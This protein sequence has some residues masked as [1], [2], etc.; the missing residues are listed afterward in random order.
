MFRYFV[1]IENVHD[2]MTAMDNK[3]QFDAILLDFAKLSIK[4][5]AKA[6]YLRDHW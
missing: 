1:C 2:M 6:F 3:T 4:T 5:Y